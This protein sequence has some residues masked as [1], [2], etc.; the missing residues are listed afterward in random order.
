LR[1][2]DVNQ[3]GKGLLCAY[4]LLNEKVS[5]TLPKW[6]PNAAQRSLRGAGR[7]ALKLVPKKVRKQVDDRFFYAVFNLT[8]V[9]NDHFPNRSPDSHINEEE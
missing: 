5:T 1:G 8:R 2:G 4:P 9:T 6:F 3:Q 7:L